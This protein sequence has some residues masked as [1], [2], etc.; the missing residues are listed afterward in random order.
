MTLSPVFRSNESID[1]LREEGYWEKFEPS[2]DLQKNTR[3]NIASL[4]MKHYPIISV[5]SKLNDLKI[6][7][8]DFFLIFFNSLL[9]GKVSNPLW[10]SMFNYCVRGKITAADNLFDDEV[11]ETLPFRNDIQGK[12]RSL[13]ELTMYEQLFSYLGN[14]LGM[15]MNRYIEIKRKLDNKMLEIGKLEGSEEEG[16]NEVLE[17]E[18]MVERVHRVRGGK[19]FE[20]A[21]VAPKIL[22]PVSDYLDFVGEALNDIGTAFQIVDDITDFEFDLGRRSH[23]LVVSE[24]YHHGSQKERETLDVFLKQR[25]SGPKDAVENHFLYS[26]SRVVQRAYALTKKGFEKLQEIGFWYKP[27]HAEQFVNSI[28]GERGDLRIK[29]VL[30]VL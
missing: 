14:Y 23:N 30:E 17:V 24:I 4:V 12:L 28:L 19:L 21:M 3:K 7:E 25:G 1:F 29:R 15:N 27:E 2:L 20:L 6:F 11:K 8:D 22:E 13:L 26:T 18:E 16:V 5:D 9:E 10:Y